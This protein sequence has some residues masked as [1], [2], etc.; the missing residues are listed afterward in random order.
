MEEREPREGLLLS[1]LRIGRISPRV[2]GLTSALAVVGL[3]AFAS[4]AFAAF[5]A[6]VDL[7]TGTA[8]DSQVATDPTGDSAITWEFGAANDRVQARTMSSAGV[9][10]P[11]H[12]LGTTSGNQDGEPEVAIDGQGDS[13]FVWRRITSGSEGVFARRLSAGGNLSSAFVVNQFTQSASPP[14]VA[15]DANGDTVF[16]WVT[17]EGFTSPRVQARTMTSAGGL[18]KLRN[19]SPSGQIGSDPQVATDSSGDSVIT[20]VREDGIDGDGDIVQARTMSVNGS[21]GPI[22]DLSAPGG[23]ALAPQV[24]T[25]PDGDTIFTWLRNNGRRDLVQA[26]T[27]T[28]G[29]TLGAT[30]NITTSGPSAQAPQVATDATGDSLLA[31]ERFEGGFDRAQARTMNAAGALGAITNASTPGGDAGAPQVASA[32]SG[33][34]V[35]TWTRFDGTNDR[36][37]ARPVS[38]AGAFGSTSSPSA[39]G[40][41]AEAPQVAMAANSGAAVVTWTRAGAVQASRGP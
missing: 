3:A 36:V 10:G 35:L 1:L 26:R 27:M 21:L 39:A 38:A 23:R 34:S 15:S 2:G 5:S 24:A 18:G 30:V 11:V 4:P 19:V 16:T 8:R 28:A 40:A 17:F 29:G 37:Q 31:W 9:L 25:D 14:E 32:S 41:D 22:M 6:P 33:A 12:E 20:W 13:V 7:Q